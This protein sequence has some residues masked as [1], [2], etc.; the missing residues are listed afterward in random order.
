MPNK[1]TASEYEDDASEDCCEYCGS[2]EC[3][4]A[5]DWACP[6]WCYRCKEH[7]SNCD[8]DTPLAGDGR[9]SDMIAT[10][11][12]TMRIRYAE[13]EKGDIVEQGATV[14]FV[15]TAGNGWLSVTYSLRFGGTCCVDRL[16][17]QE[18]SIYRQAVCTH[19]PFATRDGR[20][21]CE[22]CGQA[23]QARKLG[24]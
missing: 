14:L 9:E 18:L 15:E 19:E 6:D 13:L 22:L 3:E 2:P 5:Y 1:V 12:D 24:A 17:T 20:L 10:A 21:F 11:S 23:L 16:A 4:G 7:L 8:C